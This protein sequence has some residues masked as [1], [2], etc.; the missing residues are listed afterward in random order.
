MLGTLC[1]QLLLHRRNRGTR[2]RSGGANTFGN[3]RREA[4]GTSPTRS[5]LSPQVIARDSYTP[6]NYATNA[7]T[8][9]LIVRPL[10]PRVPP[11]SAS[12][13][14]P[15]D[16]PDPLTGD[17]TQLERRNPHRVRR[18]RDVRCGSSTVAR[19]AEDRATGG[20]RTGFRVSYCDLAKWRTR[21]VAG[22]PRARRPLQGS[23]ETARGLHCPKPHLVCLHVSKSP[24][25][26]H[27]CAS[28]LLGPSPVGQVVSA[29]GGSKL[30]GRLASPLA[31]DVA[32]EPRNRTNI[33]T[34]RAASD[35]FLHHRT[36][37]AVSPI[38]SARAADHCGSRD[39]ARVPP[40]PRLLE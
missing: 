17:R 5:R 19:Q 9:Q 15:I 30:D 26:K 27:S 11:P 1:A 16:P 39:N 25:S 3:R 33:R 36:M 22:R 8:N 28:T 7:Q 14:C 24:T 38:R 34:S 12:A 32:A 2:P 4:G 21:R 40:V 20:C 23:S 6:G 37:D 29:I 35:E 10:I 13:I 18:H 31:D